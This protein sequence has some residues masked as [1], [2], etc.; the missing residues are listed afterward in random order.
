MLNEWNVGMNN[1]GVGAS[2]H[3][4][5]KGGWT[6][7]KRHVSGLS[8]VLYKYQLMKFE[9]FNKDTGPSNSIHQRMIHI[10]AFRDCRQLSAAES[11][12]S[13]NFPTQAHNLAVGT[14]EQCHGER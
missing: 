9:H 13:V 14:L 6:A 2:T 8:L 5:T 12:Y 11:C 1:K 10:A 3:P 7:L 4:I